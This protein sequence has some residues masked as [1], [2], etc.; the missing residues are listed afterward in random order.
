MQSEIIE[1][2]M[3]SQLLQ[4]HRFPVVFDADVLGRVAH[5]L[6]A[7]RPAA[8]FRTVS[9]IIIFSLKHFAGR[10]RSHV[11]QKDLE[12]SPCSAR[13][14]PAPAVPMEL[15]VI[16]IVA[17]LSHANPGIIFAPADLPDGLTGA[18]LGQAAAAIG[19]TASKAARGDISNRAA[20]ALA[21]P[22][23][24]FDLARARDHRPTTKLVASMVDEVRSRA[25][26]YGHDKVSIAQGVQE[27]GALRWPR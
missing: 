5:L 21:H 17:P 11:A 20:L 24:C 23:N 4:R 22:S 18:L 27:T 15:N 16:R 19:F 2:E 10:T 1:A 6:W 12:T 9:T 13:P 7:S 26:G 8:I 25:F 3:L 14:Y